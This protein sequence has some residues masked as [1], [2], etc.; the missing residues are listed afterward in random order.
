ML[1]ID[2]SFGEGGG[3]ILRTSLAMS[4]ICGTAVRLINLRANRDKPGL[5][6]QHLTAVLAAAKI[7][8]AEVE[9]AHVGSREIIFL[10]QSSRRRLSFSDWHRRRGRTGFSDSIASVVARARAIDVALRRWHAQQHGA[11]F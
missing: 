3:Q 4:L 9:G 6:Q 5:R 7:G 11:A 8:S 2:G 1:T 10:P